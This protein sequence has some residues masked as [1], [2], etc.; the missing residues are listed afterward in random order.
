VFVQ[1]EWI[2][3]WYV[4]QQLV[5]EIDKRRRISARTRLQH[6]ANENGRKNWQNVVLLLYSSIADD[7]FVF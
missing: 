7:E 4:L 3:Q 6:T 1:S 2:S 5:S